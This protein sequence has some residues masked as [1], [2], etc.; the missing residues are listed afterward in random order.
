MDLTP[1]APVAKEAAQALELRREFKRGGTSIGVAR[2][3]DLANRKSLSPSTVKRMV[4]FFARHEVD[5]QGTG[6][7]VG[8]EGYPS[9]GRIAWGLWGGDPGRTWAQKMLGQF[10]RNEGVTQMIDVNVLA[11]ADIR[12]IDGKTGKIKKVSM[13]WVTLQWSNGVHESF[14]RSDQQLTDD[15]QIKTLDKGWVSLGKVVGIVEK[16]VAKAAT[17]DQGQEETDADEEEEEE[18]ENEGEEEEEEDDEEDMDESKSFSELVSELREMITPRPIYEAS[19]K[20]KAQAKAALMK[21][22]AAKREDGK[23]P[24]TGGGGPGKKKTSP[25]YNYAKI[26]QN[27]PSKKTRSAKGI[28]TCTGTEAEQ[29]CTALKDVPSQ[30]ITKGQKKI[31]TMWKGKAAYTKKYEKGRKSGKYRLPNGAKAPVKHPHYIPTGSDVSDG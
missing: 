11:G 27:S 31:V 5:K 6:F 17:D 16:K 4:S 12:R 13:P 8:D 1:P 9:A 2:A 3:R 18:G 22:A 29:V 15:C 28:W 26:G 30:G 20:A 7:Y 19:E 14:L 23:K 25:F 21:K 24:V 10:E